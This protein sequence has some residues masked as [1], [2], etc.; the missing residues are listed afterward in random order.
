[1]SQPRWAR[2]SQD[3]GLS[4]IGISRFSIR[5][6][7]CVLCASS[8]SHIEWDERA[9]KKRSESDGKKNTRTDCE[10]WLGRS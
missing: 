2:A 1:M 3:G 7:L 9:V 4:R 5:Y 8:E 6:L 10:A